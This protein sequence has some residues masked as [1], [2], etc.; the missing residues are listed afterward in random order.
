MNEFLLLAIGVS[1]SLVLAQMLNPGVKLERFEKTAFL[2]QILED[3]PL[4]SSIP[5]P[6]ASQSFKRLQKGTAIVR[7]DLILHGH[8]HW[9]AI[10]IDIARQDRSRP[11]HGRR[12]VKRRAG[13]ELPRHSR[14]TAI[15]A[16]RP[17]RI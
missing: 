1:D 17:A 2:R 8:Q 13:L 5:P 4:E 10:G 14:G 3:L 11:V 6:L 16:P 7:P 12:E 15:K 9:P